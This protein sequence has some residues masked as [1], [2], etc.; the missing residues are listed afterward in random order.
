MSIAE[1]LL[2]C[3]LLV[4]QPACSGRQV[5]IVMS[6]ALDVVRAIARGEGY[7][8]SNHEVCSFD[9]LDS[10][11]K[12][13]LPC[14]VSVGFYINGSIRST[15]SISTATGQ[16]IDM[17]TCEVFEYSSLLPFQARVQKLTDTPKMTAEKLAEM[18]GCGAP[19]IV[20][21]TDRPPAKNSK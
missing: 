21:R 16:S 12:P 13:L 7:D 1:L 2:E 17:N 20:G 3:V 15:I 11:E 14:F 18:V 9:W 5:H 10:A 19:R 4:N 6:D 8:I